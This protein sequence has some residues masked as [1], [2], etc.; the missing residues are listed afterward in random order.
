MIVDHFLAV[1]KQTKT[2]KQILVCSSREF[3]IS[4]DFGLK[5]EVTN[6]DGIIISAP[7][8][9]GRSSGHLL[10]WQVPVNFS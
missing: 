10:A 8:S 9:L 7:S 3:D 2:K 5:R 1:N 6:T 4:S